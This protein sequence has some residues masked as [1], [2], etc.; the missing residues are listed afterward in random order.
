MP[1]HAR[2]A[3]LRLWSRRTNAALAAIVALCS[4]LYAAFLLTALSHASTRAALAERIDEHGARLTSLEEEYLTLEAAITPERAAQFGLVVPAASQTVFAEAQ[5]P[6]L[7]VG[8][9]R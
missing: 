7:S 8:A 5:T 6:A 1:M 2:V 4:L 3:T 9:S